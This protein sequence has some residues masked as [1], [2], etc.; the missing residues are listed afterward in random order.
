MSAFLLPVQDAL[1]TRLNTEVTLAT[2]YD[3]V[4]GEPDGQPM[5]NYPYVIIGIDQAE[6][7]DTD[8]TLGAYVTATFFTWSRY[9][10]KGE[11][12]QIQGEIYE[13]LHR[14]A[15]N[16]SATGYRFIDSLHLFSE[17]FEENDGA[18]RHG[19]CRYRLTV[20]KE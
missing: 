16:L 12:K 1:Y 20:E 7:F 8:D 13:A 3:D 11:I 18:T 9:E 19:V 2:T 6:P 17:V 10:G 14:Q 5:A 15:A 4:P